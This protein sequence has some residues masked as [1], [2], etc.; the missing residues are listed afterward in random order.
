MNKHDLKIKCS[1][2][3]IKASVICLLFLQGHIAFSGELEIKQELPKV[4]SIG[5]LLQ[6]VREKSPR[7]AL[8]R[9]QIEKAQAE[10][11]A[12]EVLPNPKLSLWPFRSS[13]WTLE[14]AV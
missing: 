7:Y 3:Y 11:V 8:A 9:T 4:V 13:G 14:H 5:Q 2:G 10:V 1:H 12:A 6:I